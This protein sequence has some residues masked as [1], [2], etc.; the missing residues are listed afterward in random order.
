MQKQI[1]NLLYCITAMGILFC[2]K[3]DKNQNAKPAPVQTA[4]PKPPEDTRTAE[5]VLKSVL[6]YNRTDKYDLRYR[7]ADEDAIIRIAKADPKSIVMLLEKA[8]LDIVAAHALY[9]GKHVEYAWIIFEK[10]KLKQHNRRPQFA[11]IVRRMNPPDFTDSWLE[12][13]NNENET[14]AVRREAAW[15]LG[16]KAA[17]DYAKP[18][19]EYGVDEKQLVEDLF[20]LLRYFP[21][22]RILD[23]LFNSYLV[24]DDLPQK[25][26]LQALAE[27]SN[28]AEIQARLIKSFNKANATGRKNI[29]EFFKL[30]GSSR[31]IPF[32]IK[33]LKDPAPEVRTA[34][35]W[36]LSDINNETAV[37][38]LI[39]ALNDSS[40]GTVG[41]AAFVLGVMKDSRAVE[42]LIT[43]LKTADWINEGVIIDALGKLGDPRAINAIIEVAE[44][45]ESRNGGKAIIALGDVGGEEA[46]NYLRR[47]FTDEPYLAYAEQL[48][49]LKDTHS[50]GKFKVLLNDKTSGAHFRSVLAKGLLDLTDDNDPYYQK[51]YDQAQE[52]M[53]K[54]MQV[55]P[56]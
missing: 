24:Q 31:H 35:A 53:R 4:T 20:S 50:I 29:F 47:K 48:I 17:D 15:A 45:P 44:N 18:F 9:Q 23:M 3:S 36:A 46:L 49:R 43:R 54:H 10:L 40:K 14:W 5:E 21:D 27:Y 30:H 12:L 16:G 6:N 25:Y 28:P 13:L 51:I 22:P 33:G 7:K 42:P 11:S 1:L 41:A 34:A 2:C 38:P 55:D 56:F 52:E 19:I 39:K 37:L 8:P 26:I 32:F